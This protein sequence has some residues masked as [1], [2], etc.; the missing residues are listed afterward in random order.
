MVSHIPVSDPFNHK[1][2]LIQGRG[3]QELAGMFEL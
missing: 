1:M 2:S 3:I